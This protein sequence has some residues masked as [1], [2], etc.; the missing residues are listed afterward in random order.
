MKWSAPLD[1]VP[2][3]THWG[4][5]GPSSSRA[6]STKRVSTGTGAQSGPLGSTVGLDL[7]C[8]SQPGSRVDA[9]NNLVKSSRNGVG[10]CEETLRGLRDR[11][12]QTFVVPKPFHRKVPSLALRLWRQ[13][14]LEG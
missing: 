9:C 12:P 13:S 4:F 11:N 6:P 10:A 2:L 8:P 14:I 7:E 5:S 1:R 3:K